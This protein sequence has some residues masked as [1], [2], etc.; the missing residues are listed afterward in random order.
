MMNEVLHAA[1]AA[2]GAAA[3]GAVSYAALLEDMNSAARERAETLCPGAK[4]VLAAAFPYFTGETAGNLS[5]YA[6]GADYHAVL[7]RRLTISCNIL[8]EKYPSYTFVPGSDNS[9]LPERQ[10][11]WKAGLG[12]RGKNGLLLLPPYGSYVFLGSIL[13]DLA[14]EPELS[15]FAPADVCISCGKCLQ[16]CPSGALEGGVFH[17][18][19]CLSELTQKKGALSPQEAALLKRHPTVWGCDLCQTVCP[20][21]SAP[22]TAPLPEFSEGYRASLTLAELDGLSNK[23]FRA[24]FGRYAFAW[25]GPGPLKRNLEL[26]A[27]QE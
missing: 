24:K 23:T 13:S 19:R 17:I 2:S 25:R 3:W 27:D 16:A 7:L 12:L 26:K 11:A 21:N 18:E 22:K 8:L 1:L 10:A 20:Y 9:P 5:V 4:T 6:R 15:T 14:L